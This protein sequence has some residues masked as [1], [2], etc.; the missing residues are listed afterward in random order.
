MNRKPYDP[1]RFAERVAICIESGLSEGA[2]YRVAWA[3]DER[4]AKLGRK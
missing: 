1:E 4:L 2:A 3:D